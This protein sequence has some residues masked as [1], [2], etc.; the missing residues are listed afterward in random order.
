MER[1]KAALG[2]AKARG[3]KLGSYAR[4]LAEPNRKAALDRARD[5]APTL[6]DLRDPGM[7]VRA[8]AEH[9]TRKKVPTPRGGPW[10]QVTVSRMLQRIGR[11]DREGQQQ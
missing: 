2:A 8:I 11:D 1:T 3:K 9:L 6:R 4:V 10:S 7:S 5:L